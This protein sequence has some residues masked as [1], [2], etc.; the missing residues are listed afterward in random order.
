MLVLCLNHTSGLQSCLIFSDLHTGASSCMQSC[1]KCQSVGLITTVMSLVTVLI[2]TAF[3]NPF[4]QHMF[5]VQS[6]CSVCTAMCRGSCDVSC[7]TYACCNCCRCQEC[8]SACVT[9]LF[10]SMCQHMRD[11][12]LF[13]A[14]VSTCLTFL[15]SKHLSAYVLFSY[16]VSMCQHLCGIPT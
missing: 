6:I 9:F 3:T 14:C 15:S 7:G 2:V 4:T 10:I 16:V 11:I 13:S 1:A 8:V 5:T 12:P